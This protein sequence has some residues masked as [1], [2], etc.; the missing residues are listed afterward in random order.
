MGTPPTTRHRTDQPVIC[1]CWIELL[2]IAVPEF[3]FRSDWERLWPAPTDG[4]QL[5][6]I[7][8]GASQRANTGWAVFALR[9]SNKFRRD[10]TPAGR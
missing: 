2:L 10:A 1:K 8:K 5:P 4:P 6:Q 9:E 7:L 3:R